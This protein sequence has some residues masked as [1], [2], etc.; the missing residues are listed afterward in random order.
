VDLRKKR[1]HVKLTSVTK[2]EENKMLSLWNKNDAKTHKWYQKTLEGCVSSNG[3]PYNITMKKGTENKLLVNF[4]GGG[5]SWNKETAARPITLTSAFNNKEAFYISDV[6]NWMLNLIHVGL[7][8]ENDKRNPFNNWFI[9]NI[10]YVSADFH[11]GNNDFSYQTLK[12]EDKILHHHGDK[13]VT[14]ALA[15][16][17][18]FYPQIPDV[19]LI[20][21][22]SAG[23]FGCVAHAPTIHNL[24]PECKNVIV[25]SEG[26]HIRSPIWHE[27]ARDVWKVKEELGT[28]INSDDLIFDLFR[29]ARD[30]MPQSTL[31]LH[32]NSVWDSELVR[33][34]NKMIGGKLEVN[35][36]ALAR[37]NCTLKETVGKLK[38]EIP[39][40]YYYLTDYGIRKNGTTPH[41]FIGSPALYYG[42]MQDNV[43]I[44]EWLE[45][46]VSK[47]ANNVGESFVS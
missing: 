23:G 33:F 16:L 29:Y 34:T 26:T 47:D 15:E 1:F 22:V 13:N 42:K 39:N 21:G 5:L 44:A 40:Y 25:Y 30:K 24:Y 31:F 3:K 18:D 28:Y 10:P 43:S 20:M 4:I 6:P 17:K 14:A 27:I 7:L 36:D 38:N 9:L 19:L 45:R 37:F 11:L 12:G 35:P 8:K 46:A 2:D 41:I 32:S